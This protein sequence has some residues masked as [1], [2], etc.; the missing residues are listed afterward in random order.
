[1]YQ[2]DGQRDKAATLGRIK[3]EHPLIISPEI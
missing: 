3:K 1:M 2:T